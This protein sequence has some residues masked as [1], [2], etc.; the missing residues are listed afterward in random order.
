MT[1]WCEFPICYASSVD[2][3]L[4]VPCRC[5]SDAETSVNAEGLLFP[6]PA[7]ALDSQSRV[8]PEAKIT[9]RDRGYMFSINCTPFHMMLHPKFSAIG[10][11][12]DCRIRSMPESKPSVSDSV[13]RF[14]PGTWCLIHRHCPRLPL[15]L[16]SN[17]VSLGAGFISSFWT[18]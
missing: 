3:E 15:V 4:E 12:S 17:F 2:A 8:P 1:A 11:R 7:G 5:A 18:R 9:G 14:A 10:A 16:G 13:V 6:S